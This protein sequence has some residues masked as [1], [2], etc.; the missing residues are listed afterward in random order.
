M[1]DSEVNSTK[2]FSVIVSKANMI[3]ETH[4]LDVCSLVPFLGMPPG[5]SLKQ[6]D[7]VMPLKSRSLGVCRSVSDVERVYDSEMNQQAAFPLAAS[8]DNMFPEFDSLSLCSVVSSRGRPPAL[9]PKQSDVVTTVNSSMN[10][11]SGST[12]WSRGMCSRP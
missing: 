4:S 8:T 2:A 5:L 1:D 10:P 6:S 7:A 11:N 3:P 9:S 12:W